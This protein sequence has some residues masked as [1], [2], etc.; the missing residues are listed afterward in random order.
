[1][2]AVPPVFKS[3]SKK[4]FPEAEAAGAL[5]GTE[6][7]PAVVQRPRAKSEYQAP[8]VSPRPR[9]VSEYQVKVDLPEP[10][11]AVVSITP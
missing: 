6:V 10:A 1:M 9:A 4:A 8:A 11:P 3:T 2:A 7:A 5:I